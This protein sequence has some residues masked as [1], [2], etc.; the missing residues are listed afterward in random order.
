MLINPLVLILIVIVAL[1]VGW[2]ARKQLV[3][4]RPDE[5]SMLDRQGNASV[6]FVQGQYDRAKAGIKTDQ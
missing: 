3:K 5:V 4:I 6:D 1:L 2:F